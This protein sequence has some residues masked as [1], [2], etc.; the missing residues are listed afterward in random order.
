MSI[1]NKRREKVG[2]KELTNQKVFLKNSQ[3]IDGDYE[4][5]EDYDPTKKRK[6]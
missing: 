2:I 4:D 6:C 5:F 3:V 1:T